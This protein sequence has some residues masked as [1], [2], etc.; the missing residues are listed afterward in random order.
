MPWAREQL[1][2]SAVWIEHIKKQYCI[3]ICQ[4]VVN[5]EIPCKYRLFAYQV[6]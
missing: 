1:M 5:R 4:K 6:T 3:L 2:I